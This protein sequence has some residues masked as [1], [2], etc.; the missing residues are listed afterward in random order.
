LLSLLAQLQYNGDRY[1]SVLAPKKGTRK[2]SMDFD[3][4][5][6]HA[7]ELFVVPKSIPTVLPAVSP[8]L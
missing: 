5:T 7:T 3:S 4:S 1:D 8:V 6:H 2:G